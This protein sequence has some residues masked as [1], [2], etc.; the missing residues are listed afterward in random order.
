MI[1]PIF[2][3]V[4]TVIGTYQIQYT[5]FGVFWK[6]LCERDTYGMARTDFK[7][8]KKHGIKTRVVYPLKDQ[9]PEEYY[10]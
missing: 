5:Y 10:S 2:R 9:H 8:F 3:I 1:K 6:T 7:Y 4:S